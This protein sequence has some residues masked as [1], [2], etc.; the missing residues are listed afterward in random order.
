MSSYSVSKEKVTGIKIPEATRVTNMQAHEIANT[1]FV[2][3]TSLD[4][5]LITYYSD[6]SA[7]MSLILPLPLII[8]K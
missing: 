8:M 6:R 1:V 2:Y 4:Y 5:E 7:A 3:M